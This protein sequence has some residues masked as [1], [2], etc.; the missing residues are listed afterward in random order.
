[1][2]H[3]TPQEKK[4]L[5][6]ERDRRNM[7]AENAKASRKAIPR[8]KKQRLKAI[9]RNANQVFRPAAK[10]VDANSLEATLDKSLEKRGKRQRWRKIPDKPLG[11]VV[12]YTAAIRAR[13]S[14]A[15][16]RIRKAIY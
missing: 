16:R 9:R 7:Y 2:H 6:Y 8:R 1:M 12:K 14:A 11:L 4:K 15:A 13:D 3:L 5:S 10:P